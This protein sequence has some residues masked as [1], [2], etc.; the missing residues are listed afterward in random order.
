MAILERFRYQPMKFDQDSSDFLA[1]IADDKQ[2]STPNCPQIFLENGM[3]WMAANAYA[4]NCIES[5]KNIKTVIAAMN[6]LRDYAEWL[7]NENL[8]WRYFPLKKKYRCLFRYR[9][10]LIERRNEG[11]LSPSTTTAR[12]SAVVRFYRWA[13]IEHWIKTENLW[14]DS[15]KLIRTHDLVGLERTISISSSELT[16]PNRK[17][18]GTTLEDGLLPM[19]ESSRKTLLNF[20]KREGMIELYLMFVIGFFT[21]ARIDTIR[22][23][24]LSTLDTALDDPTTPNLK[25]V[26][27]GPP[28]KVKTK[29]DVSGSLL[30]PSEIIHLLQRY[31]VNTRRFIRQTLASD[32]DKDLL[33]LTST[34][35]KYQENSFTSIMS[36]LRKKLM[37]NDLGEFEHLKFHQSRATFGTQLMRFCLETTKSAETSIVFVREAMLHKDEST[38]WKYIKF[39]Q[40]EPLKEH[41]SDEFFA[42]FSGRADNTKSF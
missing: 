27:V 1:W 34:G 38:T 39:V 36:K 33:F 19:S 5:G 9:G 23:L 2:S 14:E 22:T 31:A 8:D 6:H 26:Q 3:P 37:D 17:R 28:T 11:D 40:N 24:R 18:P 32:K 35:R 13:K 30:F 15:Q 20:L 42:F 25:R 7:E 10:H 21:G 29:Y 41:L 12:M 16:I 4:I